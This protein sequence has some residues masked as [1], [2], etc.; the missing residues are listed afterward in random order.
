MPAVKPAARSSFVPARTRPPR[1]DPPLHPCEACDRW[2]CYGYGWPICPTMRWF[3]PDHR[4]I[5]VGDM[6]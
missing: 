4:P 1:H 5:D 6:I 2:G 3:C